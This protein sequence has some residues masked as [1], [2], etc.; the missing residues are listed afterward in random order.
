MSDRSLPEGVVTFVFTDIEGSTGLLQQA[1]EV[2]AELLDVHRAVLRDAFAAFDGREVNTEGDGCFFAFA[3]PGSA[4][5]AAARA[6]RD[7]AAHPL[8]A[9]HQVRVRVGMHTGEG[10]RTG[11]DYVGLAV[12]HA[13]RV[14]NAGH[15]GQVLVSEATRLLAGALDEV[16]LEYLGEYVL[17]DMARPV[18][19]FQLCAAG[20]ERE[21]PP[22]RS[23]NGAEASLPIA[24][25]SFVGRVGE[26]NT[27]LGLLA[28]PGLVTLTGAG[29]T[30]KTRLA[31]E[32][33]R[34]VRGSLDAWFVDL[35]AITEPEQVLR[36][37]AS[38]LD[39]LDAGQPEGALHRLC[40]RI[41][42]RPCL[43]VLDNCEH[44]LPAAAQLVR[45]LCDRCPELR[46]LATSRDL[47]GTPD[48][49]AHRVP[50]LDAA[51]GTTLFIDRVSRLVQP[52]DPN[53]KERREIAQIC[54]R[55]DGIPLAIELAAAR[56]RHMSI[57]D[58]AARLDDVFQVVVGSQGR[59]LQRHQTLQA[60]IDWSYDLLTPDEQIVLWRLSVLP[61]GFT[62][63]TAEAV[64]DG[65][66]LTQPVSETVFRL[67]DRSLV[68]HDGAGRY[69]QLETLRAYGQVKLRESGEFELMGDRQLSYFLEL[70]ERVSPRLRTNRFFEAIEQLDPEAPNLGAALQWAQRRPPADVRTP[71]LIAA[72]VE[73]AA[74]TGRRDY[75]EL[76][77]RALET[78]GR[79]GLGLLVECHVAF[80]VAASITGSERFG[81]HAVTAL[82]L[83][84]PEGPDEDSS[85]GLRAWT[86]ASLALLTASAGNDAEL[87]KAYAERAKAL[88]VRCDLPVAA[89]AADSAVAWDLMRAGEVSAARQ[90]LAAARAGS[91]VRGSLRFAMALFWSAIAAM[92]ARDWKAAIESYQEVLPLFR[93][94]QYKLYAAW[95][96]DHLSEAAVQNGDFSAARSYAEEGM[97]ICR[98]G[99][100]GRWGNL[101][102]LYARLGSLESLRDD[103]WQAARYYERAVDL[104][105]APGEVHDEAAMRANLAAELIQGGAC[106]QARPHL[107]LALELT[108]NLKPVTLPIG[109]TFP[110]PIAN[111]AHAV[112]RWALS[113]GLAE[114]AAELAG[115]VTAM[116][117]I[118]TAS[119]ATRQRMVGLRAAIA[120]ALGD[121]KRLDAAYARG[122]GLDQPLAR[123]RQVF[124]TA[125]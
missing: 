114:E 49:R 28:D 37:T 58:L 115:V 25:T 106:D 19:I 41:G 20:L 119:P 1:T 104:V 36:A 57:S 10:L 117:P 112:A 90:A 7:L 125:P 60:L 56:V 88:A 83:L 97:R 123:A 96:L 12:H 80:A 43:I 124:D 89:L 87:T 110:P 59:E 76:A 70:A 33:A 94:L 62:I 95:A 27:V 31:I 122:A 108:E 74:I 29:G 48:E 44:V 105:T 52:F 67:V 16:D 21:F 66:P 23:L 13:A 72:T 40:E 32:V 75:L 63:Q 9:K 15:G 42:T 51:S 4:V 101:A 71:R 85:D 65:S 3:S 91:A 92:R 24:R 64:A 5:L 17:K 53:E 38:A 11:H 100:L 109:A 116:H 34:E 39:V 77:E 93:R 50:P 111:A 121:D 102:H 107:Q 84:G 55:L 68:E 82:E 14:A 18:R 47:L 99:G 8:L 120:Q 35:Q 103:H 2:F 98:E 45:D 81:G 78:R 113:N 69:R 30:G 73:Y 6:Q 118:E 26:F 46:L 22:L 86:L 79:A 54:L 61:G